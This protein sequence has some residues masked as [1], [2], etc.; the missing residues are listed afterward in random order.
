MRKGISSFGS[1]ISLGNINK[2][3]NIPLEVITEEGILGGLTTDEEIQLT[4]DEGIPLT[5]DE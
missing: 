4:T 5:K 2:G 3:I 1:Y